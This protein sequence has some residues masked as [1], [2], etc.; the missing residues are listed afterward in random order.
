M[1][2]KIAVLMFC[3]LP[4]LAMAEIRLAHINSGEIMMAMPERAEIQRAMEA[5]SA[6]WEDMLVSIHEEYMTKMREFQERF[7]GMSPSVRE[8]LQSE[9]MD[10]ERR[11]TNTNQ[12]ATA[13]LQQLNAELL[14]PVIQR[15]R[16]AIDAVAT[17]NNFLYVFDVGATEGIV[18]VSPSAIDATPL[19]KA[20]LGIR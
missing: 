7:E 5:R 9:L 6:E 13:D 16:T 14:M 19:V 12:I 10:L 11:W 1:L 15:V 18:H 8:V 2:K 17:E 20:R 4:M 3:A